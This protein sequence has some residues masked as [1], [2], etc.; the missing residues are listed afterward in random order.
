MVAGNVYQ[1]MLNTGHSDEP[2][3]L[4][5]SLSKRL[6]RLYDNKLLICIK[7]AEHF[8]K[9]TYLNSPE[10]NAMYDFWMN[11]T[12]ED[13]CKKYH[14]DELYPSLTDVK[15]THGVYINSEY[16]PFAKMAY[17]Y[18]KVEDKLGLSSFGN[19]VRFKIPLVGQWTADMVLHLQLSGLSTKN[20]T[21]K[22]KY[23]DL[24]G[25]RAI[26]YVTL[27]VNDT[28]IARY[29]TEAMNKYLNFDIPKDK[30]QGYLRNIGQEEIFQGYLT[31]EPL[32]AE[33]RQILSYSDGAQTYK[34]SHDVVDM[35]IPGLFWFNKLENAFPNGKLPYLVMEVRYKLAPV[36]KLVKSI[37][38]G[39]GGEYNAPT[40]TA[41]DLY[42]NQ[43]ATTDEI[44]S[45]IFSNNYK[46]NL[47]R[48]NKEFSHLVNAEHGEIKFQSI[49]YH[50]ENFAVA[51][52]PIENEQNID[53]WHKNSKLTRVNI[54]EPIVLDSSNAIVVN[55]AYYFR[56]QPLIK[57]CGFKVN[58]IDLYKDL[59]E[60][61]YHGYIP[62][63][64]KGYITPDDRGWLIINFRQNRDE[65]SPSG[66]IN[67]TY[68]R[69]AYFTYT[70]DLIDNENRAKIY[71]VADCVNF[72]II[73]KGDA[74]LKYGP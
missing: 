46:V 7:K 6:N 66:W 28:E 25:H 67:N 68:N 60:K 59:P 24:L 38:Y 17:S 14:L 1:L 57:T 27:H 71:V 39:G 13:Y 4:Y 12:P 16:K 2:L 18:V 72:L 63:T 47:I 73:D 5:N 44:A 55:Q 31:T 65:H 45:T 29:T 22:C 70:S 10:L 8:F 74:K 26:E 64:Y 43:V 11:N 42:V 20:S 53:V 35:W 50:V 56:E 40:I 69:E 48:V 9:T 19:E 21:D 15:K 49:K 52:R 3:F 58:G 41:M 51:M 34:Q 30:R 33:Y 37:N 61:F 32:T 23:A 36:N 54:K 62:Y